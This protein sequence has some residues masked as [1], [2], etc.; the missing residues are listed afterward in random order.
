M[1]KI[2]PL[3]LEYIDDVKT[4]L[5][6]SNLPTSDIDLTTQQFI[7]I[8]SEDQLI[9]IGALELYGSNGLLRSMAVIYS[10]QKKGLGST[11]VQG[12][13]DMAKEHRVVQLFLLT[14]TAENFFSRNGFSKINRSEVPEAILQTEEFTNLC[15]TTA[16][17]MIR[18]L[19]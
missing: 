12:L 6:K 10:G 5:S 17:C 9:G 11:L 18:K 13:I 19:Y 14:E 3:G 16:V 4:I 8:Q 7:G 15:P 2:I 1:S